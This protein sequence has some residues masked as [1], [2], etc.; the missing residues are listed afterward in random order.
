MGKNPPLSSQ[1]PSFARRAIFRFFVFLIA[2]VFVERFCHK[3]T[4]GFRLSKIASNLPNRPDWATPPPP[5]EVQE[6][7]SQPYRFLGSGGQCYAFVSA[8]GK[9]VIKFFKHHH[10]RPLPFGVQDAVR[11]KRLEELFASV[12]IAHDRLKGETGVLFL[13]LN[14]T[15]DFA[16]PLTLIDP[17]GIAHR[18]DLNQTTFVLQKRAELFFPKAKKLLKEGKKEELQDLICALFTL[19]ANRISKQVADCDPILKRNMGFLEGKAL[20]IDLGSFILDPSLQ[21]PLAQKR[22]LFFETRKLRHL[23]KKQAP[24]LLPFFDLQLAK[25][26][27]TLGTGIGGSYVGA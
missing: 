27:A 10:M 19:I 13:H 7:L 26:F 23:L 5:A 14:P 3:Q 11:S 16:K 22:V 18:I 24:E 15:A 6:A 2:F 4:E 9:S 25:H 8:D 12:K 21:S 20:Q 17:I 1:S